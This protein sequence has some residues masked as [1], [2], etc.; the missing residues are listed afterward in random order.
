MNGGDSNFMLTWVYSLSLSSIW[1][2]L[3]R[4]SRGAA[5]SLISNLKFERENHVEIISHE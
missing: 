4:G 2:L 5:L 3:E 1:I